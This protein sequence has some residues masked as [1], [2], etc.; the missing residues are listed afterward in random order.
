MG[1]D[2]IRGNPMLALVRDDGHDVT[3]ARGSMRDRH[4]NPTDGLS[5]L[6][7]P[8]TADC[9][10]CG[11]AIKLIRWILAEWIHIIPLQQTAAPES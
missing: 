2:E 10:Y 5:P 6:D 8:L 4:G 3:P 7:F 9:A 11:Q 1:D